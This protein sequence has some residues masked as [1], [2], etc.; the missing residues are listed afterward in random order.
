MTKACLKLISDCMTEIGLRYA[1]MNFPQNPPEY[2]YFVGEYHETAE[3]E[4]SLTTARFEL[5]GY[6]RTTMSELEDCK[7]RIKTFFGGTCGRTFTAENGNGIAIL[8]D[9]AMPVPTW[10]EEMKKMQINL[11]VKEWGVSE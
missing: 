1:L 2:P 6:S 7:E 5:S 8:Y 3:T 9:S 4:D 10:D 11:Q